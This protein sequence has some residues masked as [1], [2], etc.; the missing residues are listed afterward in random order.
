MVVVV[1][2]GGGGM[3]LRCAVLKG[4]EGGREG[5]HVSLGAWQGQG[6]GGAG[7]NA[8]RLIQIHQVD[9]MS[10]MC[11]VRRSAFS[12]SEPTETGHE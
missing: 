7:V 10:T 4:G 12:R 9:P 11:M 5:E 8:A 1:V 2:E 6:L 3:L